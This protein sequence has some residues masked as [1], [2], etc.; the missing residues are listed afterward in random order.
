MIRVK[1]TLKR[2]DRGNGSVRLLSF[3]ALF[4]T[5]AI[6]A[7][8]LG[9]CGRMGDP[10][11]PDR[12]LLS[13]AGTPALTGTGDGVTLDWTPPYLTAGGKRA[14]A[15]A[16]YLIERSSWSA[17]QEACDTCAEVTAIVAELDAEK[18]RLEGKTAERWTDS[19]LTPG[20]TYGYRVYPVDSRGR[21]GNPSVLSRVTWLKVAPPVVNAT[22]QD[23]SVLISYIPPE[24]IPSAT[25]SKGLAVYDDAGRLV[26]Q[27]PAN[28]AEG[29]VT[30]L[31]N[32][33]PY[34]FSG[35]WA[36]STAEGWQLQSA[37]VYFTVT[38][39]DVTSPEPP[40]EV[41]AFGDREGISLNWLP[42]RTERYAALII[43]RKTVDDGAEEAGGWTVLARIDGAK[44][45]HTDTTAKPGVR[46][47]Y[48]L[49]SE[50]GAGN[51][52]E[53]SPL[54]TARRLKER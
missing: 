17:G 7:L 22:G 49:L 10:I 6:V 9:G 54:A 52:S 23:A 42:S 13:P 39:S 26:L 32:D 25:T 53:P 46:Y 40:R 37:P 47:G 3:P 51:R 14:P 50:D 31:D 48:R 20:Y 29:S 43:E 45:S 2:G 15:P 16:G 12:A 21:P 18:L 44:I 8:L 27:L 30:G 36:V 19:D 38:P 4:A 33:N 5:L 1:P 28:T 24:E 34:T 41:I 11:A 35:R